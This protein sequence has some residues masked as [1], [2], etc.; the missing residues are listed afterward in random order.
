M[1]MSDLR[2]IRDPV[3][4]SLKME[5]IRTFFSTW[6]RFAHKRLGLA[7]IITGLPPVQVLPSQIALAQ[8]Y[9]RNKGTVGGLFNRQFL[10]LPW[11][12]P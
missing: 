11:P 3:L 12:I 5:G 7:S 10:S 2:H 9:A 6:Q 4:S 8:L 1:Y